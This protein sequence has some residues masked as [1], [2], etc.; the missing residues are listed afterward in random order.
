MM[1]AVSSSRLSLG[2]YGAVVDTEEEKAEPPPVRSS[3]RASPAGA[4]AG[5]RGRGQRKKR[6]SVMEVFGGVN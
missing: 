1:E 4:P 2:S 5:G 6:A 3:P